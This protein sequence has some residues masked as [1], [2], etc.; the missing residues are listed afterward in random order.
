LP[1]TSLSY[2][3][4]LK[5]T[6][7][8]EKVKYN[9]EEITLSLLGKRENH[10]QCEVKSKYLTIT[11]PSQSIIVP[12]DSVSSNTL[13]RILS[14]AV[15]TTRNLS[16]PMTGSWADISNSGQSVSTKRIN[17]TYNF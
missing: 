16:S 13:A 1:E 8:E 2:T 4:T 9:R 17:K 14:S 5:H 6:V 15:S 11:H 12:S 7:N 10:F 3:V